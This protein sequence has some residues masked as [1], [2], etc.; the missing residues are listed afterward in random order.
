MNNLLSFCAASSGLHINIVTGCRNSMTTTS[1][2]RWAS[3]LAGLS[4]T[5][6]PASAMTLSEA[7]GATLSSNP[8]ILQAGENR[9]ATEFELRQARGALLPSVDLEAG[10]AERRLKSPTTGGL[11]RN[12][13]PAYATATLSQK[14]FD[15]GVTRSEIA[16]AAARVDSASFKVEE[17]SEMLALETVQAYLEY[18]LQSEVV[19]ISQENLAFHQRF[20]DDINQAIEGGTLTDADRLQGIERSEAASSRLV[21][22]NEELDA[23]AIRF[24]TLVGEP[25][26]NVTTPV[27]ISGAIPVS[28]ENAIGV[29][30]LNHP[31]LMASRADVDAADAAVRG[32]RGQYLPTVNFEVS[33]TAGEDTTGFVGENESLQAGVVARWKLYAGGMRAA[34][35][36]E[37]I[38]RASESRYGL[39]LAAREVEQTLRMA[40]SER[41]NQSELARTLSR[42]SDAN[43]RLVSSYRDQF[44]VGRR[45][46]LDVLDAQNSRLNTSILAKTSEFSAMFAEYKILAAMG[47]LVNI[48]EGQYI[49]QSEAYARDAFDVKQAPDTLAYE[50]D[51]S[52]Q[53]P[54]GFGPFGE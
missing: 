54:I 22:A 49:A 5:T 10:Y 47:E 19:R 39:E 31:A 46:L 8:A 28:L 29:A 33:A 51:E 32:A 12:L 42:Q 7:V 18:L 1:K 13:D 6:L 50:R 25:I 34:N 30:R 52:R 11:Y 14:L 24:L 45:S 53:T 4:L 40:W 43:D 27:S 35:E 48:M 23:A 2:L 20:L 36:Q 41:T 17:R 16:R 26:G 9:E 37:K 3:A 44:T 38:R 15:G 21:Q